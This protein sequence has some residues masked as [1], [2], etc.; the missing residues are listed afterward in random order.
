ML[1]YLLLLAIRNDS[2][3]KENNSFKRISFWNERY[4]DKFLAKRNTQ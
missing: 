3:T 1:Y 2:C 4:V